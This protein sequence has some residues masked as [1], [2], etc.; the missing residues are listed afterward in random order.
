MCVSLEAGEAAPGGEAHT[1]PDRLA[2]DDGT[3]CHRFI[4]VTT[5]FVKSTRHDPLTSVPFR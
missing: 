2:Q 4:I 1:H 3:T 5:T